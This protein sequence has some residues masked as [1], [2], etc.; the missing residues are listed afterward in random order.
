MK[1]KVN[2]LDLFFNEPYQRIELLAL[3]K[4]YKMGPDA[5]ENFIYFFQDNQDQVAYFLEGQK[6]NLWR[7]ILDQEQYFHLLTLAIESFLSSPRKRQRSSFSLELVLQWLSK[8]E[9]PHFIKAFCYYSSLEKSAKKF[10]KEIYKQ[11]IN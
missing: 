7:K 6:N 5:F 2:L 11:F 3:F 10:F 4:D 1:S 8:E 9:L